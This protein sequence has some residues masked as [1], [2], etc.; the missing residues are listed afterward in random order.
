MMKILPL[1][2]IACFSTTSLRAQK[3]VAGDSNMIISLNQQIDSLVVRGDSAALEALYAPD[4]VFSHGSGK[5]EGKQSWL[6]SVAKG[7][8][9]VRQH[10]SVTVELHPGMAIVRGRLSVQKKN[11][12][13][14]SKYQL[15]YVRVYASRKKHW[16]L[17]S[18]ITTHEVHEPAL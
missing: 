14:I 5:I 1:L 17:V 3:K 9:I 18:H 4:F 2:I 10:D 16:Q 6:K 12:E 13:A 7:G 15:K 8:F 11:R